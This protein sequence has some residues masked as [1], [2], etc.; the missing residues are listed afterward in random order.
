[1]WDLKRFKEGFAFLAVLTALLAI[2]TSSFFPVSSQESNYYLVCVATYKTNN[3]TV[4][5]YYAVPLNMV[6]ELVS[7]NETLINFINKAVESVKN[8]TYLG[9]P[10]SPK[11]LGV[12]KASIPQCLNK[13]GGRVIGVWIANG[14]QQLSRIKL[15]Y[16]SIPAIEGKKVGNFSITPTYT[17]TVHTTNPLPSTTISIPTITKLATV[18]SPIKSTISSAN[19]RSVTIGYS[20]GKYVNLLTSKSVAALIGVAVSSLA[21]LITYELIIRK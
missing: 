11:V 6:K 21:V 14:M 2:A 1:M 12:L 16:E 10:A 7:S 15:T 20:A 18:S 5:S 3:M 4:I 9:T 17:L 13:V 8:L 19:Q